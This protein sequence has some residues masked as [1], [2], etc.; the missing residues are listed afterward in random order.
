MTNALLAD[1]NP[2]KIDPSLIAKY[3]NNTHNS[4]LIVFNQQADVTNANKLSTKLEKANY[5]I[6]QLKS[7]ANRSQT[8]IIDYLN[9]H[10]TAFQSYY[11]VNAIQAT[12]DIN[13][14]HEITTFEEVR[15]IINDANTPMQVIRTPIETSSSRAGEPEWGL[16]NVK[17][18]SVWLDGIRGEGVI[19]GGQDTGFDWDLNLLSKKYRG[20]LPDGS[21]DHNYNWHDAIHEID[22]MNGDSTLDASHNPCGLNSIVPCDDHGHG[23]HTMG[24]MVG[25]DTTDIIGVA[26]DAKWIAC[27]NMERGQGKPSTY[28]ECFEWFISPTDLNGENPDP[29]MAPHVINNSWGC[30]PSEG[31]NP[32][33][34][35]IMNEVVDNVK[36]SGIV[37]VVS[38]GNDGSG[39]ETI[40]NPAGMFEGS[41][42]V[43]AIRSND[44]IA[45][46][47]SRGAV[48][49]DGSMRIK[50]NISAPGVGV[51]SCLPGNNFGS[52]SGT[53]M[54]GP[55]VAGVVALMISANPQIAGHVDLIEDIIEMTAVP[56]T[57][58]QDCSGYDSQVIPNIVYGFGRIDA[59]AAVKMA[60]DVDLTGTSVVNGIERLNVFPNP[61][62]YELNIL[63][64]TYYN[65][66]VDFSL[67]DI[68]GKIVQK[69]NWNNNGICT[70][71]I[72]VHQ[73]SQ[74]IYVGK[75]T[76]GKKVL[77]T[78]V[79]KY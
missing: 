46:F 72:D 31:C 4:V 34:F 19:V 11:V 73:L 67:Y 5:V 69:T 45:N 32:G 1:T 70:H 29:T 21:A 58:D 10:N 33:N 77:T 15:M 3:G 14:L 39:C 51:R 78:K 7:I 44:T 42:T 61:V 57:S 49:A 35:S 71:K 38:A 48:A 62:T 66:S 41:F 52:W 59:Y 8:T 12:I 23:S 53:S 50:P 54:A 20:V 76:I 36:A 13:M 79:I 37:V 17:A 24:T 22:P 16:I 28:I 74:G 63:S 18:D 9:E 65:G 75:L 25:G 68:Q 27:R 64:N 56:M 40:S 26:P 55:H 2:E 43:G 60:L 6:D 47:S 30:P